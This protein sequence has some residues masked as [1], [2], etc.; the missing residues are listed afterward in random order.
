MNFENCDVETLL[1]FKADAEN[2]NDLKQRRLL[3]ILLKK[4]INEGKTII[5]KKTNKNVKKCVETA[6]KRLNKDTPSPSSR[7]QTPSPSSRVQTASPS[8]PIAGPPALLC[9]T[10][11]KPFESM[12]KHVCVKEIQQI[13][14][15]ILKIDLIETSPIETEM[16]TIETEIEDTTFE[17]IATTPANT[18][19][20]SDNNDWFEE[21]MMPDKK[22]R[23]P[24]KKQKRCKEPYFNDLIIFECTVCDK[25]FLIESELDEHIKSHNIPVP[26]SEPSEPKPKENKIF[27]CRIC[28]RV[29]PSKRGLKLHL[30]S[31]LKETRE[32]KCKEPD[33]DK[34]FTCAGSLKTHIFKDHNIRTEPCNICNKLFSNK[35]KLQRHI[36]SVHLRLYTHICPICGKLL[37]DETG[38]QRHISSHSDLKPYK[39]DQCTLAF[40]IKAD[41][42]VHLRVH[43]GERP[44]ECTVCQRTFTCNSNL[45]KHMRSHGEYVIVNSKGLLK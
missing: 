36:N 1:L 33:C 29:L 26:P 42:T 7:I 24:K 40:K 3:K 19:S 39:C 35:Y 17:E 15:P 32:F 27:K 2:K 13:E 44:Y 21:Q 41:L 25:D 22:I 12:E 28:D 45:H 38:L 31:H 8:K 18:D 37:L 6:V 34:F 5:K 30:R 14:N 10:C 43:T 4:L 11:L 9:V 16:K 20:E 23:P